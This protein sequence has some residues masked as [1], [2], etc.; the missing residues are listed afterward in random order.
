MDG[1]YFLPILKSFVCFFS[2]NYALLNCDLIWWQFFPSNYSVPWQCTG[3]RVNYAGNLPL[4]A[5]SAVARNKLFKTKIPISKTF[6]MWYN[7]SGNRQRGRFLPFSPGPPSVFYRRPHTG[8]SLWLQHSVSSLENQR[9][10]SCWW[11]P[12]IKSSPVDS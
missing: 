10:L 1:S 11:P 6:S 3:T 7:S 4:T 8:F 5:Q 2:T 9:G 12:L